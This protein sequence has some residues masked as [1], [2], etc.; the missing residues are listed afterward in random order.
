MPQSQR[1]TV[2]LD[3]T[4]AQL[5]RFSVNSVFLFLWKL[6]AVGLS[7]CNQ[8]NGLPQVKHYMEVNHIPFFCCSARTECSTNAQL[9]VFHKFRG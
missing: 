9:N 6:S 4:G 3:A 7:T 5:S 1:L 2:W 8:S